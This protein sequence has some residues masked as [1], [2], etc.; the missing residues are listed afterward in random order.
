MT[1]RGVDRALSAIALAR[2]SE[3]DLKSFHDLVRDTDPTTFL[4]IVRD[5]EDEVVNSISLIMENSRERSSYD[6]SSEDFYMELDRIRKGELR[7]SVQQFADA[8][9]ASISRNSPRELSDVPSF[10]SRRGLRVWLKR[11]VKRFSEAEIYHATMKIRHERYEGKG[12]D[13]KL[14]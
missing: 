11:M 6:I 10:D 4:E 9:A 12:S 7:L 2:L 8:L 13:W 3:K 14:R 1:Q 5:I